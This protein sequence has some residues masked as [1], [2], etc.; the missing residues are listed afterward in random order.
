MYIVYP[1]RSV[2]NSAWFCI[3]PFMHIIM[4]VCCAWRFIWLLRNACSQE[5]MVI[6]VIYIWSDS[7]IWHDYSVALE[8]CMYVHSMHVT[9][10]SGHF[11]ILPFEDLQWSRVSPFANASDYSN[12][13]CIF[14][15][16][17]AHRSV[18]TKYCWSSHLRWRRAILSIT[19]D[20]QNGDH[21]TEA[22]GR[23]RICRHMQ[24]MRNRVV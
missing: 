24:Y 7:D 22:Y 12:K 9:S 17:Q 23:I 11:C 3:D 14:C 5:L 6:M 18:Y 13:T 8:I 20:P 2:N 1:L 16:V 4:P 10:H 21:Y 19:A 15:K